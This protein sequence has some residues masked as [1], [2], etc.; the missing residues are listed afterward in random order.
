MGTSRSDSSDLPSRWSLIKFFC[1]RTNNTHDFIQFSRHLIFHTVSYLT[2]MVRD[3]SLLYIQLS[4]RQAT[5][6]SSS[7]DNPIS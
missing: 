4:D 7:K 3:A 5:Q 2:L 1:P 6:R